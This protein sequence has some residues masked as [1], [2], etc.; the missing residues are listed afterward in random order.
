MNPRSA[1]S[2]HQ[3]IT[4]KIIAVAMAVSLRANPSCRAACAIVCAISQSGA[5]VCRAGHRITRRPKAT[6]QHRRH[7]AALQPLL[8]A[9]ATRRCT[10]GWVDGPVGWMI[11]LDHAGGT[12]FT[13]LVKKLEREV[14]PLHTE[15]LLNR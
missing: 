2:D 9:H 14:G 3:W 11:H 12:L 8:T 1:R 7:L 15:E 4:A 6:P 10:E 5:P 13:T